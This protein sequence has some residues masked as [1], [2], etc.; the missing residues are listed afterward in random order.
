[1]RKDSKLTQEQRSASMVMFEAGYGPEA[2]GNTFGVS[3]H[4]IRSLYDRW[5][6]SGKDALVPQSKTTRY[7][8]EVKRDVVQRFLAGESKNDLAKEAGLP[9]PKT[10]QRWVKAYREQGEDGLRPKR[11]GRPPGAKREETEL[12]RLQRQNLYLQ[13]EV[14][15]LK[16][17][18][19]LRAQQQR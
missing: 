4:R 6:I 11:R 8:F 5:R 2:I 1:M 17:L 7:A 15:Y 16:K 13:A 10:I 18:K 19:A 12:E 3:R 9:G 14:A